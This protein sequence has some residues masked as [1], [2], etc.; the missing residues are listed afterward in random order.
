MAP[1]LPPLVT[2]PELAGG[3]LPEGLSWALG[4]SVSSNNDFL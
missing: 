2:S 3:D 4:I 1:T